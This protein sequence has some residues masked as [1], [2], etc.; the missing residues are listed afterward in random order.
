MYEFKDIHGC[1][2]SITLTADGD[3]GVAVGIVLV[4]MGFVAVAV[5]IVVVVSNYPAHEQRALYSSPYSRQTIPSWSHRQR[6]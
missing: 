3:T 6:A 2:V 5:V 1:V 4:V